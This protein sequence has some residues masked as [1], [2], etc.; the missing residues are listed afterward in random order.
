[1]PDRERVWIPAALA[2][3]MALAAFVTSG[4]A[5]V[6]YGTHQKIDVVTSPPGATVTVYPSEERHR[7]P[8]VLRLRRFG[9][10][11][12]RVTH[13]GYE[14]ETVILDEVFAQNRAFLAIFLGLGFGGFVDLAT[15]ALAEQV[16]GQV[17]VTLV[18]TSRP[19]DADGVQRMSNEQHR[20][21]SRPGASRGN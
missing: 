4:C 6:L 1:M 2:A 8:T 14:P 12:L 15:G 16:P 3:L 10:Y 9:N 18:P 13:D 21:R 20:A 7:S 17:D 5:T 11:T 19:I